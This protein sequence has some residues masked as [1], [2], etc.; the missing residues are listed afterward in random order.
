MSPNS[1]TYWTT[2]LKK[3][4]DT[5]LSAPSLLSIR[6]SRP[7]LFRAFPRFPATAGE[8]SSPAVSILSS[9]FKLGIVV[10][11]FL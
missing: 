8:S 11:C 4:P 9:Y 5:R 1:S 6:F 7:Q 3:F 10:T 2:A